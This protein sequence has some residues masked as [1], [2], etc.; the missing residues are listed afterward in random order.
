MSL[1]TDIIDIKLTYIEHNIHIFIPI[2][3]I[4]VP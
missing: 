2:I 4:Y 1:F 3:H